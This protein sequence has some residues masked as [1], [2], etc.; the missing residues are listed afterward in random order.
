M[1]SF[2]G[3]K[4]QDVMLMMKLMVHPDLSQKQLAEELSIST[5]EVGHGLKRLKVSQLISQSGSVSKESAVEFLVHG[6]L[7]D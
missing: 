6:L 3:I 7:K 2:H 5:A 1:R 4:A